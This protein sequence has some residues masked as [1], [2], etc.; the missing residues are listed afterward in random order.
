M[1][2][3]RLLVLTKYML[4]IVVMMRMMKIMMYNSSSK[5]DVKGMKMSVKSIKYRHSF[6]D[7]APVNKIPS[8]DLSIL[9]NRGVH[10]LSQRC[11]LH[12][13]S[14]YKTNCK[15]SLYFRSI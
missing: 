5:C 13:P 4:M 9:G 14:I 7:S 1:A 12:M 15:F 6:L 8:W 3:R 2:K 10:S 11:R